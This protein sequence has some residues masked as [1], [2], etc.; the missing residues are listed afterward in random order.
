MRILEYV[1]TYTNVR[2]SF[3]VVVM[4]SVIRYGTSIH[5][6]LDIFLLNDSVRVC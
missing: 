1:C 2:S 3:I 6:A 4:D 5:K